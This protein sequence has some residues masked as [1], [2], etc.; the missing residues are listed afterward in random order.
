MTHKADVL[1]TASELPKSE[2][3]LSLGPGT[4]PWLAQWAVMLTEHADLFGV[5]Q[6]ALHRSVNVS[7]PLP[8]WL[9]PLI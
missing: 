8:G 1:V 7:D 6:S 9:E 2:C 4:N 3:C 5:S